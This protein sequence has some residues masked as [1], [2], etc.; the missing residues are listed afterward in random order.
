MLVLHDDA[1]REYAYGPAQGPAG[2]EGRYVPTGPVR[3]G[4]NQG[5]GGDQHEGRLEGDLPFREQ[6]SL[7]AQRSRPL[8]IALSSDCQPIGLY[9]MIGRIESSRMKLLRSPLLQRP[10]IVAFSIVCR[11]YRRRNRIR[12]IKRFELAPRLLRQRR[13]IWGRRLW[14]L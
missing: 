11:N 10:L 2:V 3:R 12:P 1:T 4:E 14:P 13:W 5:L 9:A 7:A 6:V 8:Y